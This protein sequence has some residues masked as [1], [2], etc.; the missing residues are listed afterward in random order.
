MKIGR[1]LGKIRYR[2]GNSLQRQTFMFSFDS[3]NVL[4]L[5]SIELLR[6]L[7]VHFG[8]VV[9]FFSFFFKALE[10]KLVNWIR[11][12]ALQGTKLDLSQVTKENSI[13]F[14]LFTS[15]Y[16]LFISS[17]C[18]MSPPDLIMSRDFWKNGSRYL[19][20]SLS[21]LWIKRITYSVNVEIMIMVKL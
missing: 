11:F 6:T 7:C 15:L 21:S 9:Y 1:Y 20:K 5:T 4:L 18:I 17:L 2:N 10:K 12:Q 8:S 19:F 13:N 3:E 16:H 14:C